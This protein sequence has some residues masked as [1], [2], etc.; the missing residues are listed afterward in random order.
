MY[1][2]YVFV[3]MCIN[4]QHTLLSRLLYVIAKNSDFVGSF[5]GL[6]VASMDIHD[7]FI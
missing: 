5:V 6:N 4:V 2:S 1:A 3:H 7:V